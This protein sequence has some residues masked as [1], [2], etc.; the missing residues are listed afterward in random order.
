[1]S[2][3]LEDVMTVEEGLRLVG[4]TFVLA[5][6]LAGM[7]VDVRFLWFTMFVGANLMQSAF[8]GWCPMMTILRRLGLR[9]ART[10]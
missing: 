6:A 10:A 7:F 5:S 3:S 1:M 4:G 2:S 9:H 8:T